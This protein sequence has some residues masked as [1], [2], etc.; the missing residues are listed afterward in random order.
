M[1]LF[2]L[3]LKLSCFLFLSIMGLGNAFAKSDSLFIQLY[4]PQNGQIINLDKA[5]VFSS[6]DHAIRFAGEFDIFSENCY[7]SLPRNEI[8]SV[9]RLLL[10]NK[11]GS[12]V[13]V[14]VEDKQDTIKMVL[15]PFAI[16]QNIQVLKGES[17]KVFIELFDFQ[18]QFHMKIDSIYTAY[19]LTSDAVEKKKLNAQFDKQLNSY[20]AFLKE[21]AKRNY[22]VGLI[23][24]QT[25][26][27]Y[28]NPSQS[29]Q[30][31]RQ[32]LAKN[33]WKKLE[34][35]SDIVANSFLFTSYLEQFVGF[36]FDE[37]VS[38]A[39][40][41][42]IL[43]NAVDIIMNLPLLKNA[44]KVAYD[45]LMKGFKNIEL[46]SL[47]VYLKGNYESAETCESENPKQVF[48]RGRGLDKGD[49][50]PNMK[51][52][53]VINSD[54]AD[55]YSLSSDTLLL[56]FWS[57]SCTYCQQVL[58][59]AYDDLKTYNMKVLAVSGDSDKD[60]YH[61]YASFYPSWVHIN[62]FS[63]WDGE[64]L[65]TYKIV[66]TPTFILIGSDKRVILTTSSLERVLYLLDK[67]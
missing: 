45:F 15:N 61:R 30:E 23:A 35:N 8:G 1:R 58:P 50:L 66:A 48:Q 47:V 60:V 28:R 56:V 34:I 5:Y 18:Q 27:F 67:R 17:T 6:R 64:L 26:V 25:P 42:N 36:N 37:D 41:E 4:L 40:Q 19:E 22:K 51:L 3:M 52:L 46:E 49:V 21:V 9:L 44:Y 63:S 12:F 16:S 7:I 39:T 14:V 20:T 13:D 11:S 29:K 38:T 2:I 43:Y 62:D 33:Y 55:V 24:A 57:S 65:Q 53:N 31:F 32:F 10:D 54:K 59:K